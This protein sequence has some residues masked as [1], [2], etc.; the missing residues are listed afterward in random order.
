[1]PRG[2]PLQ[3]WPCIGRDAVVTS[4]IHS[5]SSS[6]RTSPSVTLVRAPLGGGRSRCLQ[7][8]GLRA[9]ALGRSVQRVQ[10]TSASTEV[11][12]GAV[13]HLL[14][15]GARTATD[16]VALIGELRDVLVAGGGRPLVVIDD[17]PML[18]R[19]TAGV[20]AALCNAGEIDLVAS[21]R[22]GE[23]VPEPLL[24]IVF[25]HRSSLVDLAPLTDEQISAVMRAVLAGPIDGAVVVL[26]R[27]RTAGNP[28][29]LREVTRSALEA[30]ALACVEG[31]WRMQG[32]LPG[33]PQLRE[34]VLSRL[35]VAGHVLG[36]LE[37]LTL[38][39]TADL[40]ELEGM[41]G[42]EGLTLLEA[43]GLLRLMTH[44]GREVA[45]LD[46]PLVAEAIRM[47]LP[48]LRSRLLLRNHVA[49]VDAH[50]AEG[51]RDALQRAIWCLD[52]ALPTDVDSL[53]HGARLAAALQDSRSVLRLAG[54]A[55]EMQPTS[56]AG[57]LVADALFQIGRWTE[58]VGVLAIADALPATPSVRVDLAVTRCNLQLWGLGDAAGALRTLAA[59]QADPAMQPEN[60][61]R[62]SAELSSVLV[63]AGRPAEARATLEAASRSGTLQIQL[64]AAVSYANSLT[65]AGRTEDALEAIDSAI[66]RRPP[67]G[68]TGVAD[69]DSYLVA[70]AFAHVEA[71]SLAAARALADAGYETAVIRDRPLTQF[72][73]S[74]MLGRVFGASGAPRSGL[75]WYRSARALGLH[76]GLTGPV[77][78]ALHGC[79]VASCAL[80]DLEGAEL[81][82]A[83]I[84]ELPAF[85]FMAPERALAEGALAAARGDLPRARGHYLAGADE[86]AAT[87]HVTSAIWLLHESAR[88]GG[89]DQLHERI[90]ALA[91]TTDSRLA[92]ARALHVRALAVAD[93]TMMKAAAA[94]FENMGSLLLA[95]E[96]SLAGAELARAAGAQRS[97]AALAMHAKQL[98]T[99]CEGAIGPGLVASVSSLQPLT[100]RERE[101]AFM[102]AS[103]LTSRQIATQ[104]IVSQRTVSNHLQHIYDKLGVRN[105]E[106]LRAVMTGE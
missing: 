66:A 6:R 17:L 19:A 82:W 11:P 96:A 47:A 2:E 57:W 20:M 54:P 13:A 94:E 90:S 88:L 37:L 100:E 22:D 97:A 8:I 38:C 7:E 67:L 30:G 34:L 56:E 102:A 61:A 14:V 12:F 9:A 59:A 105:R 28:L 106:D 86:A 39:D 1:M 27:E 41:I 69:V 91:V 10:G 99:H 51:E 98:L 104:L 52:A 73:L 50:L 87:G 21:A 70:Q 55:F 44:D 103:G 5:V 92:S 65:M 68:V 71:G 46:R 35:D 80:G 95:A 42:L 33:S 101:V 3:S 32:E 81:A 40:R 77:R 31:V 25:A 79:V 4:V 60:L 29:F 89:A 64:G 83:E 18:D 62:L 74:L 26:L 24:D 63:N 75:R 78:V 43:R 23:T 16:P 72:W 15:A 93:P 58:T 53:L 36:A 76:V 85:G 45:S 84:D 48:A 49:W